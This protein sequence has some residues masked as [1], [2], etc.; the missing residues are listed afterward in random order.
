M[1]E[2]IVFNSHINLV[3]TTSV[4]E[5]EELVLNL[6]AVLAN[7]TFYKSEENV[8]FQKKS[9]VLELV[10]PLLLHENDELV[11]QASR[12]ISNISRDHSNNNEVSAFVI[13]HSAG[14][15]LLTTLLD[16][17]LRAVVLNVCGTFMNLF[18]IS[19][20]HKI[21]S[22]EALTCTKLLID[23]FPQIL[24]EN[25][26]K[27]ATI[28]CKVLINVKIQESSFNICY[29]ED[30]DEE[31][32]GMFMLKIL[33]SYSKAKTLSQMEI[34]TN[35]FEKNRELQETEEFTQIAMIFL[36]E[37]GFGEYAGQKLLEIFVEKAKTM[38]RG[39]T[40][41]IHSEDEANDCSGRNLI[42]NQKNNCTY[43]RRWSTLQPHGAG[44]VKPSPQSKY[45]ASS[46][47]ALT[48]ILKLNRFE[49]LRTE[50]ANVNFL[51]VDVDE[52]KSISATYEV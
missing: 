26:F 2:K 38:M 4:A 37:L 11:E 33:E 17:S 8:F 24:H 7:L 43:K 18:N 29:L 48:L 41:V 6:V 35:L 40:I 27:M 30:E 34:A 46:F 51:M 14:I 9:A 44:R 47:Q 49:A 36:E 45:L 23:L 3:E 32:L 22:R 39:Q 21:D 50:Y 20:Q 16:H 42:D 12:V 52:Q 1:H 31:R 25:D 10:L 19:G 28:C 13:K 15:E 5:H